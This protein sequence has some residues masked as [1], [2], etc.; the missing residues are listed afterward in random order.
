MPDRYICKR[1]GNIWITLIFNSSVSGV[2][3]FV[4]SLVLP[5]LI[6]FAKSLGS[7]AETN[8]EYALL[9]SSLVIVRHF[10]YNQIIA[11]RQS[12]AIYCVQDNLK[13]TRGDTVSIYI[14]CQNP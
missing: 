10:R 13:W 12:H 3:N 14:G 1:D 11:L 7:N 5:L 2:L 9:I 6:R 8:K 4:S